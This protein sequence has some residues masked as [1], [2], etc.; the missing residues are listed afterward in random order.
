[1][2]GHK[3]NTHIGPEALDIT[4]VQGADELYYPDGIIA[5][6]EENATR[7]FN[8]GITLYSTEGSSHGIRSMITLAHQIYYKQ[9]MNNTIL[10]ARNCHKAFIYACAICDIDAE[11]IYPDDNV[12]NSIAACH[13]TAS[14]LK[15][16][17]EEMKTSN[18][19]PFAVFITS[20]DYLGQCSDIKAIAD[21]CHSFNI[22]LLVDN[23]HGAY[24][25]F[26]SNKQHPMDL[27]AD[28]CCDS[29]H[30]TLPVLTGGA[31][32]HIKEG[33]CSKEQ[34]KS[35]MAITGTTSPS[36]LIMASLDNCNKLL[37][38]DYTSELEKIISITNDFKKRLSENGIPWVESE[39]LKIVICAS[40]MGMTG[41]ELG[42]ILR[43]H[44][45]EPEFCDENYLVCM[46]TPE[47][48][49]IDFEVLYSALIEAKSLNLPPKQVSPLRLE[50]LEKVCSI[51]EAV[52][53]QQRIVRTDDSE[54]QICASPT[55]S[56][57]PAI[58]IAISGERISTRAIEVMKIYGIENVSII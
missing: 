4:E 24:L 27:G 46:V 2:P 26:I 20:P 36:Y 39:P 25:H 6:S 35:S 8:T 31:Y 34:A 57:P 43:K 38:E 48:R 17:L 9:G 54:G 19:L 16:R 1:M 28:M 3:G 18:A 45:A 50:K 47:T 10:A 12:E 11:W 42:N 30:K 5:R 44:N 52:F 29:A 15:D 51:R 13:P 33:I 32:L 56:C 14:Q 21:I 58:P 41:K 7:L 55:V 23:A 40:S 49:L 22:P 53:S 37:S